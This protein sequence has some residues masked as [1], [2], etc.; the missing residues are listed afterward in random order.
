M[1]QKKRINDMLRN[2]QELDNHKLKGPR[3]DEL[4]SFIIEGFSEITIN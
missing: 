4:V 2:M 1:Q 3:E